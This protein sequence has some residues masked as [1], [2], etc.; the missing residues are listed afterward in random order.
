[1]TWVM[2]SWRKGRSL[3]IEETAQ[4]EAKLRKAR[5]EREAAAKPR[6]KGKAK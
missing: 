5:E 2:W 6:K 4:A 1:M 3:T